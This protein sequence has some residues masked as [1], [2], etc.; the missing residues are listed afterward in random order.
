MIEFFI[1]Q[2]Q[3]QTTASS[4]FLEKLLPSFVGT[5]TALLVFYLTTIRDKNKEKTKKDEERTDKMSYLKNLLSNVIKLTKQQ[6]ENVQEYINKV[7]ENDLDFH[8][9]TLVPLT[10]YNRAIDTLSKDE[11]FIS[12]N[13]FYKEKFDTTKKYERILSNID[14]LNA[15]FIQITEM[16]KKSQQFDY[17]RKLQFKE[18]VDKTISLV[19]NFLLSIRQNLHPPF[20]ILDQRFLSFMEG[21]KDHSDIQYYH[22]EFIIPINDFC[23]NYLSVPGNPQIPE[24]L[25]IAENS[26]NSKQFFQIIKDSNKE[27]GTDLTKIK[28]SL[29]KSLDDL[30]DFQTEIS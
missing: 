21:L 27:T 1:L 24:I 18:T 13:R 20:H 29:V 15:E 7:E 12:F 8:L 26:R 5:A 30:K 17:E 28:Q 2:C 25:L 14:Y 10:D 9:M 23:V 3:A 19:G 6:I 16:L 11:Y 22:D 4:S